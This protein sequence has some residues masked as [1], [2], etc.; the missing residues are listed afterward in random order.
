MAEKTLKKELVYKGRIIDLYRDEVLCDNGNTSI[1]EILHHNGG[2]CILGFKDGKAILVKQYRYALGKELIELPAG[3]VEKGEDP[4]LAAYREYEEET[5]LKPKHLIKL[6]SIIPTCG[7]SDEVI[8][9]YLVDGYEES[10]RHL[11][12][13]EEMDLLYLPLEEVEK[14]IENG[15]IVDAKSIATIYHYGRYIKK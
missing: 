1:R 8:R 4:D 7:Y 13:D 15:D 9:L 14:M 11:D 6:G 10:N 3:K 5:G 2:V 12:P